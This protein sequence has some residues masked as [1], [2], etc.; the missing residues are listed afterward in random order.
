MDKCPGL[1]GGLH[2][3]STSCNIPSVFPNEKLDGVLNELPG[4]NPLGKWGVAGPSHTAPEAE[5][6]SV[7]KA[8]LSSIG[9]VVKVI[10][11]APAPEPTKAA[12]KPV[13]TGDADKKPVDNKPVDS[14]PVV[15]SPP[16]AVE[17][18]AP[19][20]VG[21]VVTSWVTTT[22]IV[23]TTVTVPA[24]VGTA[25][26]APAGWSYK[27]CFSDNLNAR[28]LTGVTFANI[29]HREVTNTK[30]IAYCE[31]KG[32]SLAGTEYAGECFCGNE[33]KG[34][35][36]IAESKCDMLCE[37]DSSETCGGSLA[38]SV[39]TKSTSKRSQR[40]RGSSM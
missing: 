39:Y 20:K 21:N 23:M 24:P 31:S 18:P 37:G 33:L 12:T 11:T 30:C 5:S 17:T 25:A 28:A 14:K 16:A 27:G 6:P 29:G 7:P 22:E 8:P 2:D 26:P 4:N 3:P 34:S 38:L 19:T 10:S 36:S 13:D 32:F 9:N 40:I 1:I 15:T 35:S